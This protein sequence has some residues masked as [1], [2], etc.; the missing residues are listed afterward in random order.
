MK[1]GYFQSYTINLAPHHHFVVIPNLQMFF[2][3][4]VQLTIKTRLAPNSKP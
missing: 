1:E 4:V 3:L 2:H